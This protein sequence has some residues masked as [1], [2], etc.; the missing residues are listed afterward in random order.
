DRA[1]C[2]PRPAPGR[3]GRPLDRPAGL[4]R[5]A[6]ADGPGHRPGR[7]A[8]GGRLHARRR[9]HGPA[10]LVVAPR[11]H[12]S[13]P[14][15]GLDP[16]GGGGGFGGLPAGR[17]PAV[18]VRPSGTRRD[19]RGRRG[20]ERRLVPAGRW[21]RGVGA[22]QPRGRLGLRDERPGRSPRRAGT[23]R[24]ARGHR[25]GRGR[26]P[27]PRAAQ[28]QDHRA[29]AHRG[30]GALLGPRPRPGRPAAGGERPAGP[31]RP[32]R[33]GRR[34]RRRPAARAA[35]S[36]PVAGREAVAQRGRP[37]RRGDLADAGG[38]RRHRQ[39]GRARRPRGRGRRPPGTRPGARRRH[40]RARLPRRGAGPRRPHPGLRPR[41]PRHR[42]RARRGGALGRRPGDRRGPAPRRGLGPPADTGPVLRRRPQRRRHRRRQR[43][44]ARAHDRRPQRAA[45]AAHRPR[46]AHRPHPLLGRPHPLRAAQRLHRPGLRRRRRPGDGPARRAAAS[47]GVPGHA[48]PPGERRGGGRRRH[49]GARVPGHTDDRLTQHARAAGAVGARR[50]VQLLERVV[51]ALVPLAA[52]RAGVRRPAA[53]SR[54]LHR[55]RPGDDPARLVRLGRRPLHRPDG[56][57]RPRRAAPRRRR[58]PDRGDGRLLRRLHGQLDR[59]PHRPLPGRGEPRRAVGPRDLPAHHRPALV[60]GAGADAA[61][62]APVLAR[63]VRRPDP[64][65]G[66]RGAR[67]PGLP[68]ARGGGAGPVVGPR[69]PPR[70]VAGGPAAPLPAVSRREPLGT[71]AAARRRL[72]RDGAHLPRRPPRVG[73]C[74]TAS[75][76]V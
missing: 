71:G 11:P 32:A 40:R 5:A 13:A 23:A 12:R 45:A 74:H 34:G 30:G 60:L 20:A 3:A 8:A 15:H 72:V 41:H 29:A 19:G 50:P 54:P 28:A 76:V 48:G 64:D 17:P 46:S 4:R 24:H 63:P 66:P 70:R 65:P 73:E 68:G 39:L 6:P 25:P 16:L 18:H 27:P 35:R 55:L 42:R 61:D 56:H 67:G 52:G 57:H 38:T 22:G 53:R 47:R 36:R 7:A 62:E 75:D 21:G 37:A 1:R 9:R 26:G 44:P 31:P 2:A 51:V 33:G 58:E 59:R 10:H 49:P 14:G 43:P 69:L